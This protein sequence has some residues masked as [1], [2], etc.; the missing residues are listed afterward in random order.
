MAS[1]RSYFDQDS[2]PRV[3]ISV[4]GARTTVTLEAVIDTGFDGFLCLPLTTAVELGLEL[5][6]AQWVELADGSVKRDLFFSGQAGFAG[7]PIQ[8]VEIS[9][10]ES[11]DALV[12]VEFLAECRLEIDF[13][14]SVVRIHEKPR[15]RGKSDR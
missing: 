5:G 1:I 14:K 4:R 13:Q 11:E 7:R 15:R 2:Q 9:L 8:P 6:G 10:T 12:G 3:S